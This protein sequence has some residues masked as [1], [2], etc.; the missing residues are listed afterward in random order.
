MNLKEELV[1]KTLVFECGIKEEEIDNL[2]SAIRQVIKGL[3]DSLKP[4]VEILNTVMEELNEAVNE[5]LEYQQEL[6]KKYFN[7]LTRSQVI[8]HVL[9]IFIEKIYKRKEPP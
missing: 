4:L 6:D 5:I 2:V 7:P 8:K 9:N 1:L 3:A